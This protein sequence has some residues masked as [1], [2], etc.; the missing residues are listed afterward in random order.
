MIQVH[1]VY[2]S[3]FIHLLL[4]SETESSLI[5]KAFFTANLLY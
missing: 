3:H 2:T 1:Y 4:F 5:D